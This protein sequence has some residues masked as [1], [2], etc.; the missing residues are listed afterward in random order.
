MKALN[1]ELDFS[2]LIIACSSASIF[3]QPIN[4]A[5]YLEGVFFKKYELSED[6]R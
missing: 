4:K 1:K 6:I 3:L 2:A 5:I